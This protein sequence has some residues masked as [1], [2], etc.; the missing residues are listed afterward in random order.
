MLATHCWTL[1][2]LLSTTAPISLFPVHYCLLP[3]CSLQHMTPL[4]A[5]FMSLPDHVSRYMPLLSLH[6]LCCVLVWL[7]ALPFKDVTVPLKISNGIEMSKSCRVPF[8]VFVPQ[9]AMTNR[10]KTAQLSLQ[11]NG[12][13]AFFVALFRKDTR[14]MIMQWVQWALPTRIPLL[15]LHQSPAHFLQ[16]F[17]D[18]RI[19]SFQSGVDRRAAAR[20]A[21]PRYATSCSCAY[22]AA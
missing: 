22:A 3:L 6:W 4:L 14:D 17:V 5:L 16:S 12:Q 18:N 2:L 8:C 10:V 21:D 1:N 11:A 9:A 20:Q 13:A 15:T 19:H 7:L